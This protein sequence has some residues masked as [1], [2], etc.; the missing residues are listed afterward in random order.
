MVTFQYAIICGAQ[1]TFKWDKATSLLNI[2]Q[3]NDMKKATIDLQL[4]V[5]SV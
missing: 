1:I 5:Q 3:V 4:F 2:L